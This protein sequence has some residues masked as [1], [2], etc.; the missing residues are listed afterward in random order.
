MYP[1]VDR[2]LEAINFQMIEISEIRPIRFMVD[3]AYRSIWYLDE[4]SQSFMMVPTW[5][6]FVI[7]FIFNHI[8]NQIGIFNRKETFKNEVLKCILFQYCDNQILAD[9]R[10]LNK[11]SKNT[12]KTS[13]VIC[14]NFIWFV[15]TSS[16]VVSISTAWT[17]YQSTIQN[18]N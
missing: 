16:I 1:K 14:C 5:F 10:I 4:S 18:L 15:V 2:S 12:L 9:S 17:S 8:L 3:F 7:I 6:Q 13:I 11:K